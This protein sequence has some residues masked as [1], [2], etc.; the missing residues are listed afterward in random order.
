MKDFDSAL[1]ACHQKE[2]D[3]LLNFC[4][5]AAKISEY[6][7]QLSQALLRRDFPR[8]IREHIICRDQLLVICVNTEG[9]IA[10]CGPS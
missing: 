9:E 7:W 6:N 4:D 2:H 1:C 10:S 8:Y 5:Y 3:A